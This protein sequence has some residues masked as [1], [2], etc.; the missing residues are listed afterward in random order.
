[1]IVEH[2]HL[3]PEGARGFEAGREL[4][5]H[6]DLFRQLVRRDLVSRYRQTILGPLWMLLQPLASTLVFT[7]LFGKVAALGTE[8]APG[9]LYYLCGLLPW[10]L[11]SQTIAATGTCLQ[12]NAHIFGK[13]YFPRLIVP[14]ASAAGQGIPF[15]IQLFNYALVW[16]LLGLGWGLWAGGGFWSLVWVPLAAAQALLLGLG[17]GLLCAALTAKYRDLQHAIPFLLQLGFFV[18]PVVF[19]LERLP[20]VVRAWAWL[21]PMTGPVEL[22]KRGLLGVGA[23]DLPIIGAGL[24][25]TV[26][27]LALGLWAFRR[28]E[29]DFIDSI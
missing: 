29:R 11:F 14:L 9:P 15:L 3:R 6:R 21:N 7:F 10:A 22:C 8:G 27:S 20:E 2:V 1:M 23:P 4:W 12:A 28:V 26:L 5:A 25:F 16:L 24:G 13:V 19:P 17:C 18:T